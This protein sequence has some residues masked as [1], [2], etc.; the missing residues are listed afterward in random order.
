MVVRAARGCSS[1]VPGGLSASPNR[2]GQHLATGEW[3]HG[4]NNSATSKTTPLSAV[5]DNL[6]A[7]RMK[8]ERGSLQQSSRH[9]L[10][11]F[12]RHA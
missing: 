11:C 8:H 10:L 5:H 4:R 7:K 9:Y 3:R 6:K 12:C 1:P 2:S